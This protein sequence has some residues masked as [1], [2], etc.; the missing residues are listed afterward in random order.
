MSSASMKLCKWYTNSWELRDDWKQRN[1]DEIVEIKGTNPLKVL[2]LTWNRESDEFM[3]E[4]NEL[5]DFLQNKRDTKRG[6]L[7]ATAHIFD[8]VGFLSPFTIRVKCLFQEIWER[9]ISWDEDLPFDI[10]QTWHQWCSEIPYLKSI[11]IPRRYD[12]GNDLETKCDEM[13]A[14]KTV[15]REIHVFTDASEKAYCAAA[16]LRCVKE[17]RECTTSLITSK[18]KVAPLKKM[19]IPRLELMGALI[20][21]RLGKFISNNLNVN[22]NE[23]YF[24]TD[25]M[26]TFHWIRSSSKQWKPFVENRVN[27][28]FRV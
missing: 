15:E 3:F 24:W 18:M 28:E 19:T 5:I 8:P 26:I 20:G 7:Q 11:A 23:M 9:G 21:A 22:D 14:N 13:G 6:V 4:T 2:G 27:E 17:N 12:D 10:M 1:D 25:S 16:Y